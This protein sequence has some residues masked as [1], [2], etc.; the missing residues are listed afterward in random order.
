MTADDDDDFP[1]P[2]E[3]LVEGIEAQFDSRCAAC[4]CDIIGNVDMI[5]R[6]DDYDSYV[7]TDCA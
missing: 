2:G 7:H 4:G 3:M 5:T 6:S 1:R